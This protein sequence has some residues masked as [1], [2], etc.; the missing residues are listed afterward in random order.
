MKPTKKIQAVVICA[1]SFTLFA[2]AWIHCGG[3]IDLEGSR[4]V[5][6]GDTDC[7]ENYYCDG[8]YCIEVG[9]DGGSQES[10]CKENSE[11]P[12][13]HAC[14][15]EDAEC[16]WRACVPLEDMEPLC[17]DAFLRACLMVKP[18]CSQHC[19]PETYERFFEEPA[20]CQGV[21]D[22]CQD[23]PCQM[24]GCENPEGCD[25]V[26]C[27]EG[28]I[29]DGAQGG[30]CEDKG[31]VCDFDDGGCD[32]VACSEGC[33]GE[34]HEG[35]HCEGDQ[36]ICDDGGDDQPNKCQSQEDCEEPNLTCVCDTP[37][38]G[39]PGSCINVDPLPAVCAEALLRSC[40]SGDPKCHNLCTVG[41]L[42]ATF[43]KTVQCTDILLN[44]C[45]DEPCFGRD[46]DP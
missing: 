31:C 22:Q 2:F 15:C 30:H 7:P 13:N 46:C 40:H 21:M 41:E 33:I 3:K 10:D 45:R 9:K 29:N 20:E 37:E 25:G 44:A 36:C 16:S 28:C 23:V 5:C 42:D 39:E 19:N 17:Q 34:G 14:K 24:E 35:G 8:E 4:F 12:E 6:E 43:N 27:S 32:G 26:A 38:C 1:A 11:C 18:E